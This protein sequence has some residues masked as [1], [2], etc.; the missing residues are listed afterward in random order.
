[1]TSANTP[2]L[3]ALCLEER[4]HFFDMLAAMVLG[5]DVNISYI[6]L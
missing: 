2:L 1:M 4:E 5:G 6:D 3:V